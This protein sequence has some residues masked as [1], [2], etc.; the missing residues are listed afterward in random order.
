MPVG[1]LQA[2]HDSVQALYTT[3][4]SL[5]SIDD[6]SLG[7]LRSTRGM[8]HN[9][10][11]PR[12]G[13]RPSSVDAYMEHYNR[14][15]SRVSK[16]GQTPND[17][18]A[19]SILLRKAW[20]HVLASPPAS[21]PYFAAAQEARVVTR[22]QADTVADREAW[23]VATVAAI[24]SLLKSGMNQCIPIHLL[25]ICREGWELGSEAS[26][27]RGCSRSTACRPSQLERSLSRAPYAPL[28]QMPVTTQWTTDH[29]S[30]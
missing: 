8:T 4:R 2:I 29:T 7:N 16:I 18:S 11:T 15:L 26:Q 19:A 14:T 25:A 9:G 24:I 30:R 6:G 20:W 5:Y 17:D 28:P 27:S 22:Q 23:R 1:S 13:P 21:S 10:C 3:R 12:Y